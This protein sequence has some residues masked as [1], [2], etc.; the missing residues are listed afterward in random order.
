MRSAA[1]VVADHATVAIPDSNPVRPQPDRRKAEVRR[2][3]VHCA[4]F[5]GAVPWKSWSQLANTGVPF[6]ALAAIMLAAAETHYWLTLL[7]T[8]PA[9][10]LLVRL[11]IIQHDC[12]H[13][14]FL[15]SRPAND[16][17]G[18]VLSVFTI[19][20]YDVWRRIHAV[21][22]ATS[23]NLTKRGFGDITTLTVDEYRNRSWLQR[24]LYRIYR[25]PLFLFGL[26]APLFFL[27]LQRLPFGH[28][29]EPREIWRS[30]VILNGAMLVV[31]GTLVWLVGWWSVLMTAVPIIALASAIGAWLFFVQ[32]QF[33]E[34]H[35]EHDDTWDFQV[36]AI[37]GS[38][39]YE[40]PVLLR[41]FTG[42]IG[43]HHIHHLNSMIP[44]YR[45]QPC[46]E[47]CPELAEVNRL[48]L[49][50][51][52]ACVRLAL[53]DERQRRM[54]SFREVTAGA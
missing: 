2:L 34:T 49:L 38:S 48:T 41:W 20:P 45:L 33:E 11:F 7:L 13:G 27:V 23:G 19:T 54:V 24:L 1:A 53:W 18:R 39:Y 47:A 35:W 30:T 37:H 4:G 17:L 50:E 22:H 25:N 44:N 36:A 52:F 28:P 9:A 26:G 21:H 46:L 10:G 14:S 32:H 6:L 12:G 16:W 43:L 15:K 40:L 29:L 51:S 8:I 5:R 42:S 31:Y 3:A